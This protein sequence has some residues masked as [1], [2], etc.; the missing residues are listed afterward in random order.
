MFHFVSVILHNIYIVNDSRKSHPGTCSMALKV[1]NCVDIKSTVIPFHQEPFSYSETSP[2]GHLGNM[3]TSLLRPLSFSRLKKTAIHFLV[4]KA[5][6]N[7]AIFFGPLVT[8]LTVFQCIS[9]WFPVFLGGFTRQACRGISFHALVLCSK[10]PPLTFMIARIG[11]ATR[12][13]KSQILVNN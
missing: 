8:V 10:P 4:K 13:L 2:Y 7:T 3:F 5:L 6:V 12:L 1:F 11:L 9:A